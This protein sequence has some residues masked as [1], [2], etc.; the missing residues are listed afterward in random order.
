MEERKKKKWGLGKR[1]KEEDGGA[2][3]WS[4]HILHSF[5]NKLKEDK[6]INPKSNPETI[7]TLTP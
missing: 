2:A 6:K 4:R 5:V 3:Y 1:L 7:M